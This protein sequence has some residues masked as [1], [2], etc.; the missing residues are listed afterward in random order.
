[1][2]PMNVDALSTDPPADAG[3]EVDSVEDHLVEARF[4]AQLKEEAALAGGEMLS[5]S[6]ATIH[7]GIA[8][9][10]RFRKKLH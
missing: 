7:R 6:R 9:W 3:D 8:R 2:D 5:R 4:L 1:M 10:V